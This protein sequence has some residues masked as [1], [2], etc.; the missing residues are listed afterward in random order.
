VNTLEIGVSGGTSGA[1]QLV[2]GGGTGSMTL[3]AAQTLKGSGTIVGNIG[4]NDASSVTV[5]ALGTIDQIAGSVNFQSGTL[6]IEVGKT[7]QDQIDTQGHTVT[8]G[9]SASLLIVDY[10]KWR[11]DCREDF[12]P[13]LAW[14]RHYFGKLQQQQRVLHAADRSRHQRV[15]GKCWAPIL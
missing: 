1:A 10:E 9:S 13:D 6:Q 14:G 15:L 8:I 11:F 4:L 5:S 12:E 3:A 2:L 7:A